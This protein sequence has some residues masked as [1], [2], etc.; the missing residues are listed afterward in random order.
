VRLSAF[1]NMAQGLPVLCVLRDALPEAFLG[2]VIA[3]RA[4]D[5]REG[6]LALD[7]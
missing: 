5:L 3:G 1:G 4:G 7:G 6:P 2:R